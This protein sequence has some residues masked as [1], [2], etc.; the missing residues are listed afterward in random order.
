MPNSQTV[1]ACLHATSEPISTEKYAMILP[2]DTKSNTV[3][4]Q[5]DSLTA[6]PIL[7]AMFLRTCMIGFYGVLD[8]GYAYVVPED[9]ESHLRLGFDV[10]VRT[11]IDNRFATLVKRVRDLFFWALWR[12]YELYPLERLVLDQLRVW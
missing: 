10:H 12:L 5:I 7:I 8:M 4:I 2:A 1:S 3:L 9:L 11:G 6:S